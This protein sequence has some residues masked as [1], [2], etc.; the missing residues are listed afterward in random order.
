VET[1][2]TITMTSRERSKPPN[3]RRLGKAES[4]KT[5]SLPIELDNKYTSSCWVLSFLQSLYML[6]SDTLSINLCANS[7][8][9]KLSS[10]RKEIR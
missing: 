9:W 6:P 1:A 8:Q 2:K 10:P 7:I 4:G 5:N 3:S